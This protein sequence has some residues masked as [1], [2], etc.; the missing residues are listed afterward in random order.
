MNPSQF[1]KIFPQDQWFMPLVDEDARYW[2]SISARYDTF[3]PL[4]SWGWLTR[5]SQYESAAIRINEIQGNL[6]PWPPSLGSS[7]LGGTPVGHPFNTPWD[8]SFDII[9]RRSDVPA[10]ADPLGD[11]DVNGD[12]QV[13]IDDISALMRI[14]LDD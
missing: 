10:S 4:N 14:W 12:G 5:R 6:G 8:M 11:A 3:Q 7:F 13:D 9:S 1:A 2:I